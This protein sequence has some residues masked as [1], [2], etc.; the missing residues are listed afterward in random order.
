[1]IGLK[2]DPEKSKVY[3]EILN[4]NKYAETNQMKINKSKSKFILFN[5]TNSYDFTPEFKLE[6]TPLETVES[7]KL[8]GLVISNDL[9]WKENTENLTRKAYGRLWSIKRLVNHGATLNDLIDVYTKQVRSILEFGVPVWNSSLTKQQSLEFERVQ[10]AFHHIALGNLYSDY[11]SALGITGL[12][13]LETRRL[14]LCINFSKKASKHP[15]TQSLVC[16]NQFRNTKY[17][18]VKN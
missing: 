17:T 2:L 6:E 12:E 10:K 13:T 5:P 11:K 14:K 8:L 9:S 15:Q 1:M 18:K 4:I 7:M 3:K 16:T